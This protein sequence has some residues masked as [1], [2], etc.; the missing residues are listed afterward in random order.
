MDTRIMTAPKSR[1]AYQILTSVFAVGSVVYVWISIDWFLDYNAS[2]N[3]S[4]TVKIW[5]SE[6]PVSTIHAMALGGWLMT[7]GPYA[8]GV[9]AAQLGSIWWFRPNRVWLAIGVVVCL[10][11]CSAIWSWVANQH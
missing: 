8:A 5:G 3:S 6:W 1:I 2:L 11:C 4:A 7:A 10:I 9:L